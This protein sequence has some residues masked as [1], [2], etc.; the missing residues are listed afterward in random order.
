[1][2]FKTNLDP[3]LTIASLKDRCVFVRLADAVQ[4]MPKA[5]ME[6]QQ[7]LQLSCVVLRAT[8]RCLF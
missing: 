3:M 4:V 6:N 7:V 5:K 8:L 1:M 2:V